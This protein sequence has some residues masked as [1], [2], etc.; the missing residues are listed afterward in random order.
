MRNSK[1]SSNSRSG[2]FSTLLSSVFVSSAVTVSVVLLLAFLV[3]KIDATEFVLSVLSTFAL[4]LGAFAGGYTGGKR[5]RR[6]GLV[7]GVICGFAVF[8]IIVGLG[9]SFSKTVGSFSVPVKLLF[10]IVC[11]GAGGVLGVNSKNKRL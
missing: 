1:I 10:T 8:L 4:S 9:R 5:R 2:V 3:S 6:N 7:M 11:A